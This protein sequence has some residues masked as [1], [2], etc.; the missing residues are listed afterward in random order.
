M[1]DAGRSPIESAWTDEPPWPVEAQQAVERGDSV[2]PGADGPRPGRPSRLVVVGALIVLTAVSAD[3]HY[4]GLL[5]HLDHHVAARMAGWGLRWQ[6]WPRRLLSLGLWFGQRGVILTLSA[7]VAGWLTWR[8]RTCEPLLRLVVAVVS[9]AAAVYAFKLGLARDAPLQVAQGVPPGRGASFPSGHEANAVLFWG[10]ADW[11][12]R[13]W[14]T[15]A[16]VRTG[17]RWGRRVAP[18]AVV[19]TMTLLNYHWLS[20]FLGGAAV[21]VALLA[22]TLLPRW[23]GLARTLDARLWRPSALDTGSP[24]SS[25]G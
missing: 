19:L 22:L 3:V 23:A 6:T 13:T 16:T 12:V 18:I 11:S 7:A 24:G 1:P 21:G 4:G 14:P 8:H 17:V 2:N 5:T 15:P 9:V 25:R 20:D 10:L